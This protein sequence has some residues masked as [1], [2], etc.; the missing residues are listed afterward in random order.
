MFST[1][2]SR[3]DALSLRH[4]GMAELLAGEGYVVLFPD[5]FR[6]RGREE[7]CTIENRQRTI[8]VAAR[9]LD[10]LDSSKLD[11]EAAFNH[12][13]LKRVVDERVEEARAGVHGGLGRLQPS[14]GLVGGAAARGAR[15]LLAGA[16]A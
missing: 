2:P 9:R 8:H 3:R 7:I 5:S 4:Q 14:L 1:L 12:A 11:P 6:P 13:F 15:Q 16:R 10:A